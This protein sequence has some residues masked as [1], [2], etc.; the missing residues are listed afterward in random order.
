M[1]KSLGIML[2]SSALLVAGTHAHALSF[3]ATGGSDYYSLEA[4]QTI[5]PRIRAGV[6]YLN[7]ED[8]S[9]ETSLY[10]GSLLFAPVTPGVDLEVGG[11]YQY[12]DGDYAS[13]G[14]LGL[15]GSAFVDTPI[16]RVS[17]GGYGFYA[18]ESLSHGDI[19]ESHEYGAQVRATVFA[20]TYVYGGYRYLRTDFEDQDSETQHSG[21][22]FGVSVGF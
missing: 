20:Q 13:G 17:V 3:S 12:L 9:R 1:I 4:S 11:R 5:L 7:V 10:S 16:P 8:D 14:G 19:E 2:A 18:P 6:R 21:P 15:G 22:V